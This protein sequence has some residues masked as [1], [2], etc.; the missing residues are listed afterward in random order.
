MPRG[1][2]G[3]CP[4]RERPG[5]LAARARIGRSTNAP[6]AR[7]IAAIEMLV[8]APIVLMLGLSILQWGLVFHGRQAVAHAAFEAVRAA[9][10]D[11]GSDAAIE[12]GIARGLSP[13]LFGASGPEDHAANQARAGEHLAAGQ[14]AG[15]AAW[16]RLAPTRESFEDWAE[17]AR[18]ADG[19]RVEG[20][21]EIPNDNLTLRNEDRLPA[22]GIAGHRG[23][24]PIGIASGQTLADANLLKIE[25][26]Y[27]VPLTVP[28]VGRL[29]AWVMR[30]LD[31][32][33]GGETRRVRLGTV[34]LG[35][36]QRLAAP[37]AWAC[38]YY[39]ALDER[40]RP[41]PRW[42]IRLSAAIRMQ[43]PAREPDAAPVRSEDP[44]IA[45]SH[46]TGEVDPPAAFRPIPIDQVNP[47][48][49]G[50]ADDGSADR[51]PGFLKIGG[52]RLEPPPACGA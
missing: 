47:D 33:D 6:R 24:E 52:D 49:A 11:H 35:T 4:T 48:G 30:A 46:G 5:G 39:D 7:G 37:R 36:P 13:W 9:S 44:T 21:L 14:A 10:V 51:A 43:S 3:P 27:G 38:A 29:A 15:W 31:G 28:L 34:D 25:V 41:R 50:P 45:P 1:H 19:R 32:C 40:G 22:S 18:D 12:R 20:L 8:A 23:A 17:P 16:R 42:P 26:V 2:L